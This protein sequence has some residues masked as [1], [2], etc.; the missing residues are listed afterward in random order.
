MPTGILFAIFGQFEART[1]SLQESLNFFAMLEEHVC[2]HEHRVEGV[3]LG[4][5]LN[6][7]IVCFYL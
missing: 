3:E 2:R 5:F 1:I 6:K 4:M 7:C